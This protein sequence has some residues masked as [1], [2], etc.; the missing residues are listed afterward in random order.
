MRVFLMI[1]ALS[2]HLFLCKHC[3]A[4]Q[5]SEKRWL[6]GNA[7]K[8]FTDA[9]FI[10]LDPRQPR[11]QAVAVT[12]GYIV[13]A[14]NEQDI[15][16][17]CRGDKTE[18]VDLKGATVIPGF[19]NT[20]SRLV[21]TGWLYDHA[22]DISSTNP[23]KQKNWKPIKTLDA[24]LTFLEKL[25][26]S[27]GE[28]LIVSGYDET[29]IH[30]DPLTIEILNDKKKDAPTIVFYASA[31][32][33]L[34][35]QA[36]I[37]KL[38]T[39]GIQIN[40]NGIVSGRLFNRLLSELIPTPLVEKSIQTAADF[41]AG[42]GYTTVTE[43]QGNNAWLRAYDKLT[44][45]SKLPVDIIY[46]SEDLKTKKTLDLLYQDNPRLYA[47]PLLI[48]VDGFPHNYTAFLTHSYKHNHVAES[49]DWP[50]KYLK[51]SP[52]LLEQAILEAYRHNIP[53]MVEA[54][55][56]AAIDL[57][58]N[59]IQKAER[60]FP[61]QQIPPIFINADFVRDDQLHRMGK[62]G[63]KI[64]FFAPYLHYWGE[65]LCHEA[66]DPS[67]VHHMAPFATAKSKLGKAA[68]HDS[69]PMTAPMPLNALNL[70]T[71]RKIQVWNYPLNQHCPQYFSLAERISPQD[72]LEAL[73]INAADLYGLDKEKGSL[74]VGK[75]ADMTI[76]SA[77]PLLYSSQEPKVLGT[78]LRGQLRWAGMKS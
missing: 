60:L 56:D 73:T 37:D 62:A 78:I 38:K 33:A 69:P 19:I 2:T 21:M 7:E 53:V 74:M 50:G 42:Q 31:D 54:N 71:T 3:L 17:Q 70:M 58:L 12:N 44:E 51:L 63:I 46:V 18:L 22:F 77:N 52:N 66:L 32:K 8:I 75:L 36:G 49:G 55:G 43:I 76:L 25:R 24:F 67:L 40:K 65:Q 27:A 35:N 45:T 64:S 39:K 30:G 57:G 16:E 13:G 41:Y 11:A 68:A 15:I 48:Q 6:C 72:A 29:K 20:Y 26:P 4:D 23:F 47:G 14:G 61:G 34:L 9:N 28:W 59:I 5:P 10:T 1:F